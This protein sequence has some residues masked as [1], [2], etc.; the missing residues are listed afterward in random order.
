VSKLFKDL[1]APVLDFIYR[2][3]LGIERGGISLC[4]TKLRPKV[5]TFMPDIVLSGVMLRKCGE[6]RQPY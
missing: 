3:N 2:S 5:S 1:T 6:F 4:I